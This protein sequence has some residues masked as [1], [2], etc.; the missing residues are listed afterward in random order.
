MSAKFSFRF[1]SRDRK[2]ALPGS[3]ILVHD[4]TQTV[5]H[6]VSKLLGYVLFYR[7]RLLIDGELHNDSISF[8]ADLVWLDYEL[9]PKLWIECDACSVQ[10]LNKLAV[11]VPEAE[12]WVLTRSRAE[13]DQLLATMAKEKLR[14]DRYHLLAF[15][16]EMFDELCGLMK[17]RNQVV[18]FSA[19]FEEGLMQFEFNQ[20]WFEAPF[21][22]LRF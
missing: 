6:I 12:I 10:K 13:A 18:W 14:R 22:V 8:R 2:R 1:E 9:R 11:K 21:T 17:P 4:Q 3:I 5:A 15:D 20:L 19:D 16:A 7:D